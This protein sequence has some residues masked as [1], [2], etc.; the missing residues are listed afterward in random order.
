[1]PTSPLLKGISSFFS[2]AYTRAQ[3][4][5]P[6]VEENPS[7]ILSLAD[8]TDITLRLKVAQLLAI[9]PELPIQDLC[10]LLI[11]M[12]GNVA[13]A[14]ESVFQHATRATGV[15]PMLAN[16]KTMKPE[17]LQQA[18][19]PHS[20]R[21]DAMVVDDSDDDVEAV[22]TKLE[23]DNSEIW[24]DNDILASPVPEVRKSKPTS[25]S[26]CEA[27]ARSK[28]THKHTTNTKPIDTRH[29]LFVKPPSGN[30]RRHTPPS[31]RAPHTWTYPTPSESLGT[32]VSTYS[33]YQEPG[34][35]PSA[36]SLRNPRLRC[37]RGNSIDNVFVIPDTDSDLE[38][39]GMYE[40]SQPDADT[41]EDYAS[42]RD[43][44]DDAEMEDLG[45]DLHIDMVSP[46]DDPSIV[47]DSAER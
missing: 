19:Q 47:I 37:P 40:D 45:E 12:K 14:R 27:G 35:S 36:T 8:I 9:A 43:S 26:K 33:L 17:P 16:A 41:D 6:S 44:M 22:M 5:Y 31:N 29:N 2:P 24:I 3:S 10:N 21:G 28:G 39:D 11:G 1:M 38:S 34:Y 7:E 4:I 18:L 25:L 15:S 23:M 13:K 46:F 30:V 42:N 32:P 20:S